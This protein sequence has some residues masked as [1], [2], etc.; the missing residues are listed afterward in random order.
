M[1]TYKGEVWDYAIDSKTG[2]RKLIHHGYNLVVDSCSKLIA[3]LMLGNGYKG[4]QYFAVGKGSPNWANE[5]PP[6]PSATAVK[7]VAET[8]RKEIPR[9]GICFIDF[10]NKVSTTPT[11]RI[12]IKV[13]FEENEANGELREL[14]IFGGNATKTANSGVMVNCKIHPLI[15]KTTGMKLERIIR[16]TF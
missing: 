3:A 1:T 15:C 9:D 4:V 2:E 12:Q 8:F 16:F 14:G 7:L 13:T 11:N 5:A 10:A 6:S